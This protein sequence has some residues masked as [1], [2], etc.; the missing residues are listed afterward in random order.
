MSDTLGFIGTGNL[1][2]A[3]VTALLKAG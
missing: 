2:A 3:I 1:G